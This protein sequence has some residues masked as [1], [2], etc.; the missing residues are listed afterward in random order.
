M[1]KTQTNGNFIVTLT[2]TETVRLSIVMLLPNEGRHLDS[3]WV[4][5]YHSLFDDSR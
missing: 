3:I 2:I 5:R 1:I 4:K